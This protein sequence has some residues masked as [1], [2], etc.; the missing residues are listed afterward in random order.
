MAGNVWEWCDS[1]Y[2]E[3]SESRVLRGGSFH[4]SARNVRTAVRDFLNPGYR[5]ANIGFRVARTYP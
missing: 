2:R 1:V 5:S 3:G 4:L